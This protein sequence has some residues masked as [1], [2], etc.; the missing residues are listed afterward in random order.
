MVLEPHCGGEESLVS[1][2]HKHTA[3]IPPK[4]V[5]LKVLSW[6]VYNM[7]CKGRTVLHA[8]CAPLAS[9]HLLS[10]P[11]FADCLPLA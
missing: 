6:V 1:L 2:S 11:G 3:L 5:T 7:G 9:S 8:S 4:G 10:T